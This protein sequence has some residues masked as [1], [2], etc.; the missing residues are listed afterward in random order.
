MYKIIL[1][2]HDP[3]LFVQEKN[4]G[5]LQQ[6]IDGIGEFKEYVPKFPAGNTGCLWTKGG[7]HEVG[8]NF[9]SYKFDNRIFTIIWS[10]IRD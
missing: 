9:C 3:E 2:G 6:L 7:F 8:E 10:D 1:I 5:T 4:A